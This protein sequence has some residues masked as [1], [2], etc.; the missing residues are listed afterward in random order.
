MTRMAWMT[1]I[2]QISDDSQISDGPLERWAWVR[3]QSTAPQHAR[4]DSMR[5]LLC[6]VSVAF[7]ATAASTAG[8]LL[9]PL[10]LSLSLSPRR[11][12]ATLSRS[13]RSKG[14]STCAPSASCA[15]PS[16][17]SAPAAT[18]GPV[19]FLRV[20]RRPVPSSSDSNRGYY[21]S[22]DSNTARGSSRIGILS[23]L[24]LISPPANNFFYGFR[25]DRNVLQ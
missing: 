15:S 21:S 13:T 22:S 17:R 20:A 25:K 10:S 12:R 18:A 24:D 5:A 2:A 4:L 14:R 1:R 7:I 6:I 23:R 11:R 9:R 8:I 3:P 19:P 16:R